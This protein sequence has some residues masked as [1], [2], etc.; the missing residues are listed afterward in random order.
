MS[1]TAKDNKN[2]KKPPTTFVREKKVHKLNFPK[3]APKT[4]STNSP[5]SKTISKE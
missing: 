1:D 2:N 3:D 4:V 5:S